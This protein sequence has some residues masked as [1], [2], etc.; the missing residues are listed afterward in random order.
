MTVVAASRRAQARYE[1]GPDESPAA[2]A[3][4]RSTASFEYVP[5]PAPT[6]VPSTI[7]L[8]TQL[9]G[10]HRRGIITDDDFERKK[11]DLPVT[12]E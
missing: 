5:P 11:A 8:L 3:T 4:L 2:T 12:S 7:D 6:G 9:G 1:A 10:L